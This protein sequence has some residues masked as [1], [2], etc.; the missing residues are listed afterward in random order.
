MAVAAGSQHGGGMQL[1]GV[2]PHRSRRYK[3]AAP[4]ERFLLI[5]AWIL[6]H[7]AYRILPDHHKA[8]LIDICRRW[9]GPSNPALK[10]I[11]NN[12]HIVYGCRCG[13]AIGISPATTARALKQLQKARFL[14]SSDVYGWQPVTIGGKRR[15]REYRVTFLP[16]HGRPPTWSSPTSNAR[17]VMLKDGWLDAPAYRRLSAAA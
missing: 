7:T 16:T 14:D 5:P 17:R 15:A 8:V 12:G 13:A 6:V 3:R 1:P 2:K 11:N 10:R 9:N 4:G